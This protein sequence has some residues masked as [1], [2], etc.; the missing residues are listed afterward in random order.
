MAQRPCASAQAPSHAA[1][2]V[3][4]MDME[5]VVH[6]RVVYSEIVVVIDEKGK[7]AEHEDVTVLSGSSPRQKVG[8][9]QERY[10]AMLLG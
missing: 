5:V 6:A 8:W 2:E 7:S 1:F 3:E 9:Y 10:H 4:Q